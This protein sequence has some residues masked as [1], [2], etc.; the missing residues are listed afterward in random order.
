MLLKSSIILL[1]SV[2]AACGVESGH[3]QVGSTGAEI[4]G[5]PYVE[6][7][8]GESEYHF[9]VIAANHQIILSSQGYQSRT[10]ALSG[11]LSVMKNAEDEGQYKVLEAKNGEYYFNLVAKNHKIIGT[12]EM[13]ST[14]SN[15]VRGTKAVKRA[16][17][18]YADFM[19][20]RTGARFDVFAGENGKHYFNLHAKNGEVVLSS[21]G[22]SSKASAM[23]GTFSVY[24][25]GQD[26]ANFEVKQASNGQYYVN[27]VAGNGQV[28]A[29]SELYVTKGN[30][31]RAAEGIANLLPSV[32]LL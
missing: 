26:A 13:Y 12:S 29:T 21:Q 22:Y 20:E 10:S 1:L 2:S 18:A 14:K 8:K 5:R 25:N 23:N 15:A 27:L 16:S 11:L 17:T 31:K 4:S 9:N 6:L 24:D 32:E 30:A 19:E 3:E 7:F 28:I